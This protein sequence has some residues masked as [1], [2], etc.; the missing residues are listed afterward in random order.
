MSKDEKTHE[1]LAQAMTEDLAVW[2]GQWLGDS[3]AVGRET[4]ADIYNVLIERFRDG[5][6]A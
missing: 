3:G 2:L 6:E 4:K 1:L 5:V